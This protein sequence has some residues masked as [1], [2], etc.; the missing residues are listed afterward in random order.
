MHLNY[1]FFSSSPLYL[2]IQWNIHKLLIYCREKENKI[3]R[4]AVTDC[5]MV[6]IREIC[7]KQ[8]NATTTAKKNKIQT[9]SF[10]FCF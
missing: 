5:G 2:V 1:F 7:T 6:I 8:K 3:N 9:I 4:N 10:L